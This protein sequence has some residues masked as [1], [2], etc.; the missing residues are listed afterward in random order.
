MIVDFIFNIAEERQDQNAK[1]RK[2]EQQS[3]SDFTSGP[4]QTMALTAPPSVPSASLSIHPSLPQRPSY[5]FAA[6]ADSIGLGAT[7]T[8]E[9]IQNAPTAVQALAGSN[10]DVVANRRAIRMANM[11]AAEVLKAELSGLSPVKPSASSKLSAP[12]APPDVNPVSTQVD[13]DSIPGLGSNEQ[14]SDS[15]SALQPPIQVTGDADAN[16]DIDADANMLSGDSED[17]DALVPDDALAGTKR[18]FDEG[19]A[20]DVVD[21]VVIVEEEDDDVP[22]SLALKVNPDGTVQQEDTVKY[23]SSVLC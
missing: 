12:L 19:P 11:S 20:S 14:S 13:E 1:R 3:R 7:P 4:S 15:S 5:D 16:A 2:T 21:D 8:P 18:K 22:P 23:D 17:P 10:R 6:N 9:S